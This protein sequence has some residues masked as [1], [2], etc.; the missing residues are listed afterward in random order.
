MDSGSFLRAASDRNRI[1]LADVLCEKLISTA[2]N[3]K[4][5]DDYFSKP[6][7][8]RRGSCSDVI[9]AILLSTSAAQDLAAKPKDKVNG[10]EVKN[11]LCIAIASDMLQD[12]PG[13]TK[14][15]VLNSRQV[16][17]TATT[18]EKAKGLGAAAARAAGVKFTSE[19]ETRVVMVGIGSGPNPIALDRNSFLLAYW[20]GF[21]TQSGVK[22]ANQN[23]SINQAC[24]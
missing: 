17:L 11:K 9:G 4:Q 1:A 7:C 18:L 5:V 2:K 15:S 22:Q 23:Q 12:T 20:E 24:A 16:A 10:K 19:V 13:L 21:F 6:I 3:L 14:T 8:D